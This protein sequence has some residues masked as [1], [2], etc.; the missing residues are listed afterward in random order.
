[1]N[2]YL[3]FKS[4]HLIA[5]ISWMAGLLYRHVYLFT[6][7]GKPDST[8]T[9]LKQWRESFIIYYDASHVL[10]WLGL[11]LIHSLGFGVFLNYG[12]KLKHYWL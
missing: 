9:Y 2:F 3:L 11:L 8:K 1:M 12:C 4:L 5:V 10:S 6:R 7:R